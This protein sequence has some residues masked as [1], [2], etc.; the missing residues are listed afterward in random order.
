[1]TASHGG[2]SYGISMYFIGVDLFPYTYI[3]YL[4][5]VFSWAWSKSGS[6]H[7]PK[8]QL[9]LRPGTRQ[10]QRVPFMTEMGKLQPRSQW[11]SGLGYISWIVNRPDDIMKGPRSSSWTVDHTLLGVD[12]SLVMWPHHWRKESH[13]GHVWIDSLGHWDVF[14][15]CYLQQIPTIPDWVCIFFCVYRSYTDHPGSISGM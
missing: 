12:V 5:R 11:D 4:T 1:M 14:L 2:S 6:P 9:S 13:K 8:V 7:F 15:W 10:S 3:D